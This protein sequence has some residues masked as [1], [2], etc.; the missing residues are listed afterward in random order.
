MTATCRSFAAALGEG[1]GLLD[2][3]SWSAHLE[4]CAP[5]RA[6]AV[7][8][9]RLK[10]RLAAI[11]PE[12]GRPE[13]EGDRPRAL[14]EAGFDAL[15]R[16]AR[17]RRR[18]AF[19][20]GLVAAV[21]LGWILLRPGG[22]PGR[23]DR[24]PL[25][26]AAA[27]LGEVLPPG[28][29]PRPERLKED[30]PLVERCLVAVQRE[31][32]VVR[33]AALTV[34]AFGQV[35]LGRATLEEVLGTW[36]EDLESPVEVASGAGGARHVAEAL[37]LRRTATLQA[38]LKAAWWQASRGGEAVSAQ[39][40]VPFLA[41]PEAGVRQQALLALGA[42]PTYAP[43]PEVEA[44]L[45]DPREPL[46]VRQAA[47]ACLIQR[48]GERGAEI[49]VSCLAEHTAEDL[50]LLLAGLLAPTEAGRALVRAR[51]TDPH[52]PLKLALLYAR[53]PSKGNELAPQQV[54]SLFAAV[55]NSG[56]VEH[57]LSLA[58]LCRRA[59][60]DERRTELQRLWTSMLPRW[61]AQDAN[62]THL[63]A[64]TLVRWDA[65]SIDRRRWELALEICEQMRES[66]DAHARAFLERVRAGPDSGLSARAVR[67]LEK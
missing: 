25:T 44:L 8:D 57:A 55:E 2:E 7:M 50:E 28:A 60:L 23:P 48:A 66:L 33:R 29:A 59:D 40:V 39:V 24:D 34:L 35:D 41:T 16:D 42:D 58:E 9:A 12:A 1:A 65:D 51:R 56:E 64:R 37:A 32:G 17:M 43:G 19:V 22:E 49:V 5:C 4:R 53:E 54:S 47:G 30:P 46:D 27:L 67:L 63:V 10:A 26:Q 14:V 6:V 18:M 62:T 52:T 45:R 11:A 38:A 36:N 13:L 3:P 20:G 21:V 15:E 61:R 31:R